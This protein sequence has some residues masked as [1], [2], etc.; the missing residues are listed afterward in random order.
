MVKLAHDGGLGQEVPPLL[1]GVASLQGLDGHAD[2]LLAGQLQA[3]AANLAKL[4]WRRRRTTWRD[5]IRAHSKDSMIFWSDTD[6][7]YSSKNKYRI[8]SDFT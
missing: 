4:T 1:V 6:V 7:G 3:P 2:L 5:A 8:M